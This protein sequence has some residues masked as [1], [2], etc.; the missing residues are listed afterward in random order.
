MSASLMEQELSVAANKDRKS[1]ND[2][3][4]KFKNARSADRKGQ[5]SL[6]WSL[7][8]NMCQVDY[9]LKYKF[10]EIRGNKMQKYKQFNDELVEKR[11]EIVQ[12]LKV[13]LMFVKYKNS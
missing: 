8:P 2:L 1:H 10:E 5:C 7:C 12:D 3:K 11:D 6:H 13:K 9:E 4:N